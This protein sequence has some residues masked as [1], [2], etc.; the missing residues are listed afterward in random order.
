[1]M[2]QN[3]HGIRIGVVN[4]SYIYFL[5]SLSQLI[6]LYTFYFILSSFGPNQTEK[7]Y[8]HDATRYSSLVGL[9]KGA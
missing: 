2:E 3:K 9:P 5:G 4:I 7:L 1:M 6:N 8:S